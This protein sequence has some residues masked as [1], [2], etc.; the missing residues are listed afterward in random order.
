MLSYY[1]MYCEKVKKV[2]QRTEKV[3]LTNRNVDEA[4]GMGTKVVAPV[5]APAG[6]II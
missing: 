6:A 3:A 2:L 1:V 5:L 4:I